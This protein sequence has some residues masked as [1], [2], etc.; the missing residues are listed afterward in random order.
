MMLLVDRKSLQKLATKKMVIHQRSTNQTAIFEP[1]NQKN[2]YHTSV[3]CDIP[4]SSSFRQRHR[5]THTHKN[6]SPRFPR[7]TNEQPQAQ[8]SRV[9][10][11]ANITS[12]I[13]S[14]HI[15]FPLLVVAIVTFGVGD[16]SAFVWLPRRRRRQQQHQQR[17]S[18]LY[19][20]QGFV[21]DTSGTTNTKTTPNHIIDKNIMPRGV[22]KE[23][24]PTKICVVCQVS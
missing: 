2:Y 18:L 4:H 21:I 17:Y 1:D 15:L 20:P 23:H 8:S 16:T 13:F 5:L 14:R 11:L 19:I 22:K 24:L 9:R 6:I 10:S 3:F 12:I 7:R